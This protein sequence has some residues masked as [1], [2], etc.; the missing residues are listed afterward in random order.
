MPENT[1]IDTGSRLYE[2][3]AERLRRSIRDGGYRAG[4]LIGSEHGLARDQSISRVTVRRASEILIKEGLLERRPGK[5]LYVRGP[6]TIDTNSHGLIQVVAGNLHWEPALQISRGVQAAARL[7]GLHVQLYDA[8]GDMELDLAMLDQLPQS[9][10]HGAVIV[11]LHSPAFIDAVC[12]LKTT[13]FPFVLADQ[14]MRDM[15]VPSVTADN[16][17]GGMQAGRHLLKLG[18][19]RIAFMGDMVA[20]T[21]QDRLSGFRDA[22]ADAGL[23]FDRS[24]VI[25]LEV[26][27]DRLADWST[28]IEAATLELMAR[29][30]PPTALF[31]SCDAIARAAYRALADLGLSVPR[32]VS[33]IGFDD[34][35]LA[36]WLMPGLTTVRQPFQQM[37]R[38]AMELL[39]QRIDKPGAA[40]QQRVMPVELVVRGSTAAPQGDSAPRAVSVPHNKPAFHTLGVAASAAHTAAPQ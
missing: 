20:A 16:Y 38:A 4:Q 6:E 39:C 18:H 15:E 3:V 37:G 9:R 14:R 25:D 13:D 10:A 36:Q 8:H 17:D 33:V 19:R 30:N 28:G 34:D 29:P 27:K 12:R 5:G 40:V 35:P 23:P 22:V 21:V 26:G 7:D 1:S 31:V 24:M 11:S 2:A 32:D